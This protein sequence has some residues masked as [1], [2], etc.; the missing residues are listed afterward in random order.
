MHKTRDYGDIEWE[1]SA[2]KDWEEPGTFDSPVVAIKLELIN[3]EIISNLPEVS[4]EN[5]ILA[6]N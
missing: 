3:V 6:W 5:S 2:S 1:A 4:I